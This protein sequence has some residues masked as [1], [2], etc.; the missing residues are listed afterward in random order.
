MRNAFTT[1]THY[2]RKEL[3]GAAKQKLK[4]VWQ[5]LELTSFSFFQLKVFSFSNGGCELWKLAKLLWQIEFSLLSH[6]FNFMYNLAGGSTIKFTEQPIHMA[7]IL[8]Q[9]S[10]KKVLEKN[11]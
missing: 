2:S 1:S 6:N 7:R 4:Y 11:H 9:K 5:K 3:R 8:A 10:S